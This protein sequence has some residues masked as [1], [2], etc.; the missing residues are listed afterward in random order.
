MILYGPQ[1]FKILKI[2]PLLT[3]T[4]PTLIPDIYYK[5]NID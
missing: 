3:L 1:E 5:Y 4:Y 2:G